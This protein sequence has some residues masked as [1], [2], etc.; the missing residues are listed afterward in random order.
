M[1]GTKDAKRLPLSHKPGRRSGSETRRKTKVVNFRAT[2]EERAALENLAQAEGLTF[3][4][5]IRTCLLKDVKTHSRRR[6]RADEA[7]IAKLYATLNRIGN[8]INQIAH[9]MN[10]GQ[11]QEAAA[12]TKIEAEFTATLK[13]ARLALG[14]ND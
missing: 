6:P 12:L 11:V 3:G 7:A 4:S 1:E 8:N 5:Y 10:A 13:A 9:A 14:Y 2:E